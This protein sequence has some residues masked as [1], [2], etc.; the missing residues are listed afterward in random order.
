MSTIN[1]TPYMQPFGTGNSAGNPA[2]EAEEQ[3]AKQIQADGLRMS[4]DATQDSNVKSAAEKR[5]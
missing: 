3:R 4:N 1:L 2:L 5:R